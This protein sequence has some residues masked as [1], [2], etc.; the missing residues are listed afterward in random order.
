M[1][2]APGREIEAEVR[3]R[4]RKLGPDVRTRHP[5]ASPRRPPRVGEQEPAVRGITCER[6]TSLRRQ[7][8][9]VEDDR[10]I[11]RVRLPASPEPPLLHC[12][13]TFV[14]HRWLHAPLIA[15]QRVGSEVARVGSAAFA[16][17]L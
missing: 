9:V 15:E 7:V 1:R 5:P 10:T 12:G 3:A 11:L 13:E 2:A 6:I 8:I 17:L 14:S 16:N 4:F